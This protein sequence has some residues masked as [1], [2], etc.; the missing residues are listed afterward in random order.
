FDVDC[1]FSGL[2]GRQG[3]PE[4][5][6]FSGTISD[7]EVVLDVFEGRPEKFVLPRVRNFA[8]KTGECK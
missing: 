4:D 2:L 7:G 6:H 1:A 5:H 3:P 8:A